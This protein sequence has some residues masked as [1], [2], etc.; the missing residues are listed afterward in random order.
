MSNEQ[1]VDVLKAT[2]DTTAPGGIASPQDAEAFVDLTRD[3]T[4][5]LS[6]LRIETG[7][8]TSLNLDTLHL[9]E[10]V[11]VAAVE[12]TAPA[13][14]D[15]TTPARGRRQLVPK[16]VVAAFDVSF[17]FLRR[18]IRGEMVNEDLNA[19]FAKRFGKDLV[20]LT[21][22][23]DT[24]LGT[25]TRTNKLLRVTDGIIKRAAADAGVYKY[26]IPA[27]PSYST[28]VFPGMIAL[29]PKDYRDDRSALRFF[30]SVDVYDAYA[31]EI[32]SRPTTAGDAI[33]VGSWQNGLTFNGIKVV[34][35]FGMAT[36]RVVLTLGENLA[37]GFGS[38]MTVGKDVNNRARMLQVTITA[39]VDV[40]YVF[41]DAMVLGAT[42]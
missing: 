39:D 25:G 26:T 41:G 21:M 11:T 1:L 14:A 40:N 13:E 42:A 31:N 34:P 33:L 22:G 18:N 5:V 19:L 35:V 27:N 7:I 6:E 8:K 16:G 28:Q 9:A 12:A 2:I 3:Q 38:E 10:P 4:A 15:V 29:L 23:G 17:D 30:C 36:N 32:G 24:A 37:V 20:M